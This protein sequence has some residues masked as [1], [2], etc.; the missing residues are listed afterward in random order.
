MTER[1]D[2][3]LLGIGEAMR[4][5]CVGG[6]EDMARRLNDLGVSEGVTVRCLMA[7]PLGD[8][9][10]YLCRGAVIALRRE[11]AATVK[12]ERITHSRE[13]ADG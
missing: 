3:A 10:A 7:S 2:L 5:S 12:G 4:V 13:V 9:R 6:N 8:P 11:D 1:I